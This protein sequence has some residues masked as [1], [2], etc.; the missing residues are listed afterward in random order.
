MNWQIILRSACL[1]AAWLWIAAPPTAH[2]L[3]VRQTLWGFDGQIVPGTFNPLSVLVVNRSPVPFD[4]QL[5][6]RPGVSMGPRS[7]GVFAAPCYLAPGTSR[8]VQFY[9]YFHNDYSPNASGW[10]LVWGNGPDSSLDLDPPTLAA[11]ARVWFDDPGAVS[12]S[13]ENARL[14]HFPDD[15][16][17]PTV[18]AADGLDTAVLDHVPRWEAARRAAFLDWLRRGGTLHLLPDATGREPIFTEELALL[19][20]PLDTLRVGSGRVIHHHGSPG[21]LLRENTLLAADPPA[22]KLEKAGAEISVYDMDGNFFQSLNRLTRPRV[23]WRLL[24][25]L[26]ALY[27]LAVGPG[28]YFWARRQRDYR[29]SLLVLTG[30][31]AVFAFVFAYFGRRG[32]SERSQVLTI[33]YARALDGN[34]YD[35]TQWSNVFVTSGGVYTLT[36]PAEYNLYSSGTT[37]KSAAG[38][39]A[40]G[41]G[42]GFQVDLPLFS[43]CAVTHRGVMTGDDTAVT[44]TRWTLTANGEDLEN[45]RLALPTDFPGAR[46]HSAWVRFHGMFHELQH[47]NHALECSG[48]GTKEEDFLGKDRL[49]IVNVYS[50][51]NKPPNPA[52]VFAS[53]RRVLIASSLGGNAHFPH[54]V[55]RPPTPDDQAELFLFL[56]DSPE[57]FRLSG[58]GNPVE[59]SLVLYRRTVFKPQAL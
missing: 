1:A 49:Q 44:P 19:N 57:T 30:G 34:R 23:R 47:V 55:S 13:S 27:L 10:T 37:E 6:L 28:H 8:W 39:A 38:I 2:A 43:S 24:Y 51:A 35:V 3:E 33:A 17:P 16:F 26:T 12:S 48:P 22:P 21:E 45:F 31:V 42:G 46:F 20:S 11:P 9:P 29:L 15:L 14:K 59:P 7:G 32:A 18:A 36:H 41:R 4:G 25:A 54:S 53:C 52:A 56:N 50:Y 58:V 40:S 5:R